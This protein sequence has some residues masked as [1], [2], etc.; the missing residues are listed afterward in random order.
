MFDCNVLFRIKHRQFAWTQFFNLQ[1]NS[2][3]MCFL[4][5]VTQIF[6]RWSDRIDVTLTGRIFGPPS[7]LHVS[8]YCIHRNYFRITFTHANLHVR[9]LIITKIHLKVDLYY[10]VYRYF[11]HHCSYK[12]YRQYTYKVTMRDVRVIF[13]AV[14]KLPYSECVSVAFS[15]PAYNVHAQYYSLIC[16]LSGSILFL[17][18]IS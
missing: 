15:Y 13:V 2:Y 16:S 3:A 4:W 1:A 17:H 6:M 5:G 10:F 14:E 7:V 18:I 11:L 8:V 12:Q 9:T